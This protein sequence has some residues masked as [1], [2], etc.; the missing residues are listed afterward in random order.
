MSWAR[1]IM[2]K[3]KILWHSLQ[4]SGLGPNSNLVVLFSC[5]PVQGPRFSLW[6]SPTKLEPFRKAGGWADLDP[7]GRLCCWQRRGAPDLENTFKSYIVHIYM[8][9]SLI[10]MCKIMKKWPYMWIQSVCFT[11]FWRKLTAEIIWK[12]V[13]QKFKCIFKTI[14]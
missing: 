6:P 3:P 8:T 1:F 10:I 5:D 12:H 14:D 2:W 11:L 13:K 7:R 4:T 9:I